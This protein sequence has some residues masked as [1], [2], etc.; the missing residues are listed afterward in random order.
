MFHLSMTSGNID[1]IWIRPSSLDGWDSYNRRL[2]WTGPTIF[3]SFRWNCNQK[4]SKWHLMYK[5]CF[6]TETVLLR[7]FVFFLLFYFIFFF[8]FSH[9]TKNLER[10]V[11]YNASNSS[12]SIILPDIKQL[13]YSEY[14]SLWLFNST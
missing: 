12:H 3:I 6:C 5:I 11:I 9:V 13:S 4:W 7:L 2:R 14:D 10:W 1:G 8:C